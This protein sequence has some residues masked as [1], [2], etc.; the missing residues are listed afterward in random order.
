MRRRI[1]S[2]TQSLMKVKH[3]LECPMAKSFTQTRSTGL[4]SY[5]TQSPVVTVSKG[6]VL[7]GRQG[8]HLNHS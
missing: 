2:S 7:P 1:F 4:I 5:T 8:M 6:A 3:P